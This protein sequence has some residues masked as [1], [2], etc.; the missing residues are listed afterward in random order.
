MKRP[1]IALLSALLAATAASAQPEEPLVYKG[2]KVAGVMSYRG[3]PWLERDGRAEEENSEALLAKLALQPGQKVA[4]IG[5]GSGYYSRRMAKA[6]APEGTVY[7]VD[8]QPEMLLILQQLAAREEITNIAPIHGRVDDPLLPSGEIDWILLVDV[9]HE[10]QDPAAMLAHLRDALAPEG[11]VALLE[12]RLEGESAR[13]IKLE[14][15]MSVEQVRAEWEPAG[16]E[17][18]E[19]W[20]ELPTQH[21]FIFRAA[22]NGDP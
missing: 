3:A 20:E 7:A 14:H 13:H 11:R 5:C 21:L 6:V 1:W 22:P 12:F 4:D 2:R 16:F 8:I 17:L 18:V 10:M 15:R 19:L 9:Y